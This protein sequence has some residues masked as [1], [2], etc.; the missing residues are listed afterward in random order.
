M[1]YIISFEGFPILFG[2]LNLENDLTVL[3]LKSCFP[4]CI[5]LTLKRLNKVN[6]GLPLGLATVQNGT[7]LVEITTKL[8]K[9]DLCG[10]RKKLNLS[11]FQKL[12][13]MKIST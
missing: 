12:W 7:K 6:T 2:E 1:Y 8:L 13:V 5:F 10:K 9:N 4:I 3:K 11:H